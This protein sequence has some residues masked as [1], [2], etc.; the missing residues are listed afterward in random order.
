MSIYVGN[1]A[2]VKKNINNGTIQK[3]LYKYRCINNFTLESIENLKFWFAKPS[4]FNDPFD[5]NLSETTN[6]NQYDLKKYF[7]DHKYPQITQKK[8]M[9]NNN[10]KARDLAIKA[11]KS[12]LDNHGIFS[13]SKTK[14]NILMWSH[15]AD[16]HKGIVIE[17]NLQEDPCFF[18]PPF[19]IKYEK[20]YEPINFYANRYENVIQNLT[21]KSS[22][23]SYEKETRIIKDIPGLHTI[24]KEALKAVHFG[25]KTSKLKIQ[26]VKD[27]FIKINHTKIK[28]YKSEMSHGEFRLNFHEI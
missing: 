14:N 25:C 3:T 13:L 20:S 6:Y 15:Y 23:W 19:E 12:V 21:F 9:E 8:L 22:D 17:F 5:S 18:Q 16:N 1:E 7:M 2:I 27:A 24:K 11:R 10:K 4:T 26:E 28:F